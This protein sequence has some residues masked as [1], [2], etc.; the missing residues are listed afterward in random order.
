MSNAK[1]IFT[2]KLLLS[3]V[4]IKNIASNV[5]PFVNYDTQNSLLSATSTKKPLV[6]VKRDDIFNKKFDSRILMN[7]I[8]TLEINRTRNLFPNLRNLDNNYGDRRLTII[9]TGII[10]YVGGAAIGLIFSCFLACCKY[11]MCKKQ[12]NT[13]CEEQPF[14]DIPPAEEQPI[15]YIPPAEEQPIS[16]IPPSEDR[17][18]VLVHP[19]PALN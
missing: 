16:D 9:P 2:T 19:I 3:L 8:M 6:N 7:N 15:S 13:L 1:M 11:M 14:S 12:K 10:K 4:L 17:R 5:I 18:F